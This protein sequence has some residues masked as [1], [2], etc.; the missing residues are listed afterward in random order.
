ME[1][2][3]LALVTTARRRW[4]YFQANIIEIP[5]EH[6]MKQILHKPETLGRLV[7]WAIELSEFDIRYKQ[8]I[9]T[10][11]PGGPVDNL[12]TCGNLWISGTPTPHHY[13]PFI[14]IHNF[15]KKNRTKS[16]LY[17]KLYPKNNLYNNTSHDPSGLNI[18]HRVIYES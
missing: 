8:R 15:K 10:P 16:P 7:K 13:V 14:R 18:P 17:K 6:Q 9:V 11:Y 4:P 12:S 2:L 1:N 3:V 5:T